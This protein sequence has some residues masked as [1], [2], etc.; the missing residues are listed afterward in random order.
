MGHHAL[1]HVVGVQL[2]AL[3][4]RAFIVK[5]P[6]L[7]VALGAVDLVWSMHGA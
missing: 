5:E 3:L 1:R 6:L 7:W 4:F 2:D